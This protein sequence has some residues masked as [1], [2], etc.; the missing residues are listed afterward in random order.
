MRELRPLRHTTTQ[1]LWL[2]VEEVRSVKESVKFVFPVYPG[3]TQLDFT[4]PHQFF[5]R[6]SGS[7]LTVASLGGTPV[8]ANGLQFSELTDLATIDSC[9]VLCVPGG[10]GCVEMMEDLEYLRHIQ[11][12]ANSARY[13]TSVC[14]GSL[15]LGAA[16]LLQGRRAAC[17][18]AWRD[19]LPIFGA[20]ADPSRVVRDGN[21]ITGGGITAGMDFALTLIGELAGEDVAEDIQLSL[22]YAPDPPFDAGRPD[23]A[24]AAL[25]SK[26]AAR[27]REHMPAYRI[28]AARAAAL[29]HPTLLPA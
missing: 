9:N 29:C 3:V 22:E 15:L 4:G 6:L 12:L 18:W 5:S 20:I 27:L 23:T 28:V 19:L 2:L 26:T 13:I 14:T 16:G 8:S 10:V 17:H 24:P 25:L 1:L 21:I 11:R 7:E